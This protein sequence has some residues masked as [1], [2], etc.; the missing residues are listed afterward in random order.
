[1]HEAST[2]NS[3]ENGHN[4]SPD[5]SART[6][7]VDIENGAGA[8]CQLGHYI[9]NGHDY[10]DE[11]DVFYID[12]VD[13]PESIQHQGLG[14][15]VVAKAIQVA[16]QQGFTIGRMDLINPFMVNIVENLRQDGLIKEASYVPKP[17]TSLLPEMPSEE[18]A[19]S[20]LKVTA[21]QA[22]KHLSD[23]E[24]D[25]KLA[26]QRGEDPLIGGVLCVIA[27]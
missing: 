14:T 6:I 18:V 3:P 27:F 10:D 11:P 24:V 7:Q 1:M 26:E 9:Y 16:Q 4:T 5:N 15:K 8:T 12:D 2:G 25:N 20:E 23:G 13:V 21:E 17:G 19:K 22:L